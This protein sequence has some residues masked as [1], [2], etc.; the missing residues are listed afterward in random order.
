MKA[1]QTEKISKKLF[2]KYKVEECSLKENDLLQ[3]IGFNSNNKE[4]F[5]FFQ[6]D[7]FSFMKI[8]CL[9]AN[10]AFKS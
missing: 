5:K 10:F 6:D 2:A 7:N 1:F 3:A 9:G 8:L 4:L